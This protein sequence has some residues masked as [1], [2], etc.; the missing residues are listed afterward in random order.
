MRHTRHTAFL[1]ISALAFVLAQHFP[2]AVAPAG[3]AKNVIICIADGGGFGAVHAASY[4][5]YGRLG[6]QPY[7]QPGW[8][9]YA[10]RT[11]SL[12][13]MNR[14]T[15]GSNTALTPAF[16]P[17]DVWDT[18]IETAIT[19][20]VAAGLPFKGY[21]LLKKSPTDSGAAGTAMS[22]GVS[23]WNGRVN[24]LPDA[25]GGEAPA[26]GRTIAEIARASGRA[27]GVI[28][29]V[30]WTDATPACFG[31][32]HSIARG[33]RRDIANEML[34][35]DTL[36]VIMGIGHPEYD[37]NGAPRQPSR[38]SDYDLVGGSFTWA[39]LK[40]GTHAGGWKLIEAKSDFEA[41]IYRPLRRRILGVPRVAGS[42]QHNRQTRDWNG[43][44]RVDSA[45][46]KVSPPFG[47]PF[48]PT[49]P[50]LVTMTR[51]ALSVLSTNPKGFYLMIEG[52]AVDHAAHSNEPGRLIEE[53]IDFNNSV[54]AVV[55][56]VNRY[57]NWE[58]TL[59]IVTA[60]HE[61]GLV[62]GLNSDKAAFE[63][64]IS[65][66]RGKP[67]GLWFNSGG[68]T[69]S[70]VPLRARGCGAGE[71]ARYVLGRDP[72]Y[73]QYVPN[74]A[75]FE[76]MRSAMSGG[77]SDFDSA[78]SP[79]ISPWNTAPAPGPPRKSVRNAGPSPDYTSSKDE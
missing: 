11:I 75:I 49:V 7:D 15:S 5:Q 13:L 12:N 60:D 58:E 38:E 29:S 4:Y 54:Q 73:G 18:R 45:D 8:M 36:D 68:H 24:Y 56:W 31:G 48:I 62:W 23:T 47:D 22:T 79:G 61:T 40:S 25:D 32:A 17:P 52:G 50:S 14:D 67:V 2:A 63:R 42:L 19:M 37:R 9:Q 16:E 3:A 44:G 10:A 64:I 26:I 76:V 70:L 33:S 55:D 78:A 27:T 77:R 65:R 71:F 51:A 34:N 21:S 35:S 30:Q 57:S 59:V 39:L 72:V 69:N 43:D 46:T 66:G 41:L 1:L 74:T 20:S 28:T 6:C 53:M